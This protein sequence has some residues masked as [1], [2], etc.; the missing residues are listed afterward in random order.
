MAGALWAAGIKQIAFPCVELR[1]DPAASGLLPPDSCFVT[2]SGLVF[3]G[4]CD[5]EA[6]GSNPLRSY[7]VNGSKSSI[8]HGHYLFPNGT[9]G[10]A[11]PRI[12]QSRMPQSLHV[13]VHVR[14][15]SKSPIG[16]RFRNP[17]GDSNSI[18]HPPIPSRWFFGGTHL[19]VWQKHTTVS[20]PPASNSL[21][22]LC[23]SSRSPSLLF[24]SLLFTHI[25][26]C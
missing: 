11:A 6:A 10:S 22:S 1:L 14:V 15:E 12:P 13:H 17:Y 7:R 20:S 2:A 16:R 19:R 8:E 3:F 5:P 23:F 24:S 18:P 26:T 21:G 25:H 9:C 4:C